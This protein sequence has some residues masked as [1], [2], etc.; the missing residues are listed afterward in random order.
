MSEKVNETPSITEAPPIQE[1]PRIMAGLDE[2]RSL[3][4]PGESLRAYAIQHRLFALVNRRAIISATS[5]RFIGMSR[6]LFGGFSPIDVRWQDLKDI[7][8]D[9]GVFGATLTI[10]SLGSPDMAMAGKTRTL[11]FEGLRRDEAE[12][13]YRICQ[14]E[15][16]GWR[17]KRR[18]REL[19]ELRAKSGGI[20]LSAS[21]QGGIAP[22]ATGS[23]DSSDPVAR[24]SK[25]KE[26]LA[27]G[28]IN[29]SEFES[30]KARIVSGM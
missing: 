30:L 17:E 26:M 13:V 8:I 7:R 27:K 22:A 9:V 2:L 18:V 20:Q 24:L 3:L 10:I 5:G 4:V 12:K 19:E 6:G 15:E 1:D 21:G 14:A 23:S 28:L 29:D 25:A 11:R 16:Q